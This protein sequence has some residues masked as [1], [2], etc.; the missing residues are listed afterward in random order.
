MTKPLE[1]HIRA[2]LAK[3]DNDLLSAA[4]LIEIEPIILDNAGFFC[5]QASEKYLKAFLAYKEHDFKKTHSLEYLLQK[6]SEFDDD[7]D[8]IDVKDLLAFAVQIRY[9][10]MTFHRKLMK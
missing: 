10:D 3:A 8:S 2:W 1:D 5:Q 9:P 7:F 6:C 4:R